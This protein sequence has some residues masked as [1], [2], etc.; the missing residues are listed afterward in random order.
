[1]FVIY[2]VFKVNTLGEVLITCQH[3]LGRLCV[4]ID[5]FLI[6]PLLSICLLI[7]LYTLS[8][9]QLHEIQHK[10][11]ARC[12]AEKQKEQEKQSLHGQQVFFLLAQNPKN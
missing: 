4:Y 5:T 7:N 11:K 9:Y 1:M 3:L 8:I 12:R 6:R 10:Q 2:D